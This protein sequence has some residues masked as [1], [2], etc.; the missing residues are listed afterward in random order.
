MEKLTEMQEELA[1]RLGDPKVYEEAMAAKRE[2]WQAK[3]AEVMEALEK[4]EALW[5]RAAERLEA[6]EQAA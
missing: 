1:R 3:Y 5:L 6:A 4:A 2:A